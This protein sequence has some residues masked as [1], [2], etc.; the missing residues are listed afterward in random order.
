MTEET[1]KRRDYR[2]S[3]VTLAANLYS[4]R[5]FFHPQREQMLNYCS[6]LLDSLAWISTRRN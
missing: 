1:L 5:V 6:M 3:S 4:N 2:V